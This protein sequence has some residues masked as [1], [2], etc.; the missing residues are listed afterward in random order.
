MTNNIDRAAEVIQKK[1]GCMTLSAEDTARRLNDAGLLAPDLPKPTC[2]Y[3][4]TWIVD[5]LEIEAIGDSVSLEWADGMDDMRGTTT[6]SLHLD[7]RMVLA[8][9]AAHATWE[10]TDE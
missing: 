5:G 4:N 1:L 6:R 10:V 9:L 7:K 2:E 3:T 8:I